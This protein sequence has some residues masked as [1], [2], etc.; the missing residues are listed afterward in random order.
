ME[1]VEFMDKNNTKN[2]RD[3]KIPTTKSCIP[4]QDDYY[5]TENQRISE[6][7][8]SLVFLFSPLYGLPD[9]NQIFFNVYKQG[10]KFVYKIYTLLIA[11]FKELWLSVNF[12]IISEFVKEAV[13]GSDREHVCIGI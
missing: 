2:S 8:K 11:H 5:V 7:W 9:Y 13:I 3:K 1:P 4:Q 10:Y 6:K 12:T